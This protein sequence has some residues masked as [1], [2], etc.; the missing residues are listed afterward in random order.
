MSS[1]SHEPSVNA[2]ILVAIFALLAHLVYLWLLPKPIP[3]IPHNPV[4]SIWGDIPAITNATKDGKMTFAGYVAGVVEKHGP[5][6]Q[7]SLHL[8][9]RSTLKRLLA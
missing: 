7:V 6:L 3:G 1:W 2:A 5:I 4:A 8:E 9:N